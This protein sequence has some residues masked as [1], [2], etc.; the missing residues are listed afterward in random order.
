MKPKHFINR[1]LRN[2]VLQYVVCIAATLSL[3]HLVTGIFHINFRWPIEYAGDASLG[4]I[5]KGMMDGEWLPYFGIHSDRLAAPFGFNMYDFP[6]SDNL[7][8]LILKVLSFFSKDYMVV[9]N[10]YFILTFVLASAAFVY[11][12][13]Y[14]KAPYSTALVFGLLFTFLPYHFLRGIQHLFLVSY[15]LVP[16]LGLILVWIW[17]AKPIFFKRTGDGHRLDLNNYKSIFALIVL[18]LAG[19]GGVY[20]AFFFAFFALIAGINAYFYRKNRYHLISALLL[21]AIISCSV[22]INILPNIIYHSRYGENKQVAHR[23]VMESEVYGLKI[24][25][26]LSPVDGHRLPRIA[27]LKR[28]YNERTGANENTT[29]TLGLVGSAAYIF[30][31]AYIFLMP[32]KSFG[33]MSRLSL[34]VLTGTLLSIVGGYSTIVARFITPQIRAYNRISVYIAFFSFF[35]LVFIMR[36]VKNGMPRYTYPALLGGLFILGFLDQTTPGMKITQAYTDE[37]LS[38]RE[39]IKT[40]EHTVPPGSSIWQLPFS[41]FPESRPVNNMADYSHL[42]AYLHS[43]TL[44]WNYGAMK[45]R[46]VQEW[47]EQTSALPAERLVEK[48]SILGFAGIYLDRFGYSGEPKE[49]EAKLAALLETSPIVSR[50]NRLVFFEMTKYNAKVRQKYGQSELDKKKQQLLSLAPAVAIA[51]HSL[52]ELSSVSKISVLFVASDDDKI[53]LNKVIGPVSVTEIISDNTVLLEGWSDHLQL[54]FHKDEYGLSF[55]ICP[56]E[57]QVTY[58]DIISNHEAGFVGYSIEQ[59]GGPSARFNF[60]IGNGRQWRGITDL[61]IRPQTWNLIVVNLLSQSIEL[62]LHSD[63]DSLVRYAFDERPLINKEIPLMVGN[64]N[65]KD[66]PFHG[67]ISALS[68]SNLPYT[69]YEI[70]ALIRNKPEKSCGGKGIL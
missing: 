51:D 48:L 69:R 11:A 52:K 57:K 49:I 18:F 32:R 12:A 62:Y 13:R 27:R 22:I 65:A 20:Y 15:F 44:K 4:F 2:I 66:R 40:I 28:E 9:M 61:A 21:V 8:L 60:G 29:A 67:Q 50:N 23:D 24:A 33:M 34:F 59:N 64:W 30:L 68:L 63:K 58:A 10:W 31:S 55:W 14:Y 36:K 26:L 45:G 70:E 35:A 42:R 46:P 1:L 43:D 16:L 5:F 25:Q 37:Y 7:L 56:D 41:P 17:S 53:R 6:V 38:D 39:F 19:G 47:M 3:L 54:D